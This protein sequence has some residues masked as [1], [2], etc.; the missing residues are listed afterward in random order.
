MKDPMSIWRVFLSFRGR[1]NR[2]PYWIAGL[3]LALA[4]MAIAGVV[5]GS[6]YLSNRAISQQELFRAAFPWLFAS[7]VVLAYPFAAVTAKRLH[8]RNRPGLLAAL[9]IGPG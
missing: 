6:I 7:G 5:C 2:K 4:S 1:L 3:G 8:D 9:L